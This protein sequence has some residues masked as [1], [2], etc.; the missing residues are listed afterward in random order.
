[1]HRG[2]VSLQQEHEAGRMA[3]IARW[4]LER[5]VEGQQEQY[6]VASVPFVPIFLA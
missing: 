3:A 5:G 2:V 4:T 6:V 1:M